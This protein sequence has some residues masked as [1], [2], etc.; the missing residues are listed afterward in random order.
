M[1][2]R[3]QIKQILRE[4]LSKTDSDKLLKSREFEQQVKTITAK[5]IEEFYKIM[6]QKKNFWSDSISK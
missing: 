2:D 5:V 3:E 6:W 1:I 4:E